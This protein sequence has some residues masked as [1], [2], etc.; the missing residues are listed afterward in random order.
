[1]VDA[2]KWTLYDQDGNKVDEAAHEL[3]RVP[4]VFLFGQRSPSYASVGKSLLGDPQNH[5]DVYN[6]E[7]E[8]RELL[9]GQT[10]SFIN[11]PLGSGPDAPTVEQA[12][13]MMGKQTGTMNVLFSA[14]AA[15]I[16]SADAANVEAYEQAISTKTRT[17]YRE[18]GVQWETD[19]KDAEA[20]GSLS[21]KREEMNT[22]LS[23]MANEC[24][25]AEYEL[26]DL[27]YRWKY[28]ADR[29]PDRLD[30]DQVTIQY[31]DHFTATPFEDVLA[32]VEAAQSIGM[33]AIFLK[34]LRKALVTKFEGM[35]SLTPAQIDAIN[36]AIDTAP[37]DPSPAEGLQQ[38]ME[39]MTKAADAGGKAPAVPPDP[40]KAA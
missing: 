14:Q 6:L 34:E 25:A 32:Q 36:T 15:S 31:P 40:A 3:G 39:L 2:E 19:S 11:L 23:Q 27:F 37:D 28:G 22:R 8:K 9:R 12:Q 20:E 1:V 21:L 38:G 7:S 33:P 16:L 18:A 4:F 29:G 5:I 17:I 35:A 13:A 10:F 30:E 24:Q 26:A